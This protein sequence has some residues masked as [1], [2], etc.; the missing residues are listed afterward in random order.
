MNVKID[1]AGACR[2]QVTVSVP[3]DAVRP[4]YDRVVKLFASNARIPGFRPGKAPAALVETRFR[5]DILKETQDQLLPETYQKMIEKESLKPVAVVGLSEVDLSPEKGMS[6]QVTLDTMPT[7]KLPKYQKISVEAPKTEVT[8]AEVDEAVE[9]LRKRMSRYEDLAEGTVQD[10]D[11]VKVTYRGMIDGQEMTAIDDGAGELASGE[12]FWIPVV[13]ESEFL[14]GLNEALRGTE[15]G[16]TKS[17]T[18]DF[19]SDFRIKGLS[20][21]QAVYSFSVQGLRR[22]QEPELNESFLKNIGMESIEGLRKRV[23]DDLEQNKVSSEENRQRQDISTYLLEHTKI[24]VPESQVSSE[25]SSLMRSLL[26]RMAR[27][28]GTR[29]MLEKH[30]DEIMGSV[31]QQATDR[32]K[33]LYILQAIAEEEQVSVSDEDVNQEIE[34]LS[35]QYGMPDEKFRAEIEKQE[36]G[37]DHLRSDLLQTRVL[38][39][40]LSQAKIK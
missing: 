38:D 1:K 28:G 26:T 7:F 12:D 36:D 16:T 9:S 29:E 27:S 21:R 30:R 22:L 39:H 10:Q 14:P 31:S 4:V 13:D 8:E 37:M 34:R 11:M 15:S 19:P 24:E 20:G 3:G 2:L 33:L 23:R 6:F 25:T 17:V 40:L 32:V 5:K 18:I 35:Q